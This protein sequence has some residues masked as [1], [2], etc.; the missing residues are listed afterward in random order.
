MIVGICWIQNGP[1]LCMRD[2]RKD[3][4]AE[5]WIPFAKRGDC[6]DTACFEIGKGNKVQ[7]IHDFAAEGWE[8]RKEFNDFWEWVEYAVKCMIE[9]NKEDGIE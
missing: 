7:L 8:Q 3:T 5:S 9:Y 6:D 4:Q 1:Y 2:C